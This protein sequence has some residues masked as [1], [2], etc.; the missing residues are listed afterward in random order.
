MPPKTLKSV[1]TI[2]LPEFLRDEVRNYIYNHV[3]IAHDERPFAILSDA[4]LRVIMRKAC[5]QTGAPI[6]RIHDLL[7]EMMYGL[8][9]DVSPSEAE[10]EDSVLKNMG[11]C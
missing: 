11:R 10:T 3:G 8:R 4:K 2:A 5:L 1:R 7:A 6:I 9:G